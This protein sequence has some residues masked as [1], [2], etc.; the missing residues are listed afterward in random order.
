MNRIYVHVP[1]CAS[2][3]GYCAFYSIPSPGTG[4]IDAY[5][6]KMEKDFKDASGSCGKIDSLFIGGG[7]PTYLPAGKLQHLFKLIYASFEITAASEISIECNPETLTAEKAGI[8]A[9]FANRVSLGIQSFNPKFRKILGRQ[10]APSTIGKAMGLLSDNGISNIGCDLIYAIPEQTLDDWKDDLEKAVSLLLKHIS[11][12]SLTIE[13]GSLLAERMLNFE[14]RIP[15]NELKSIIDAKHMPPESSQLEPATDH[16]Q[17][18]TDF[19]VEMW[20]LAGTFLR[21]N[22]FKR[23]EISN[24]SKTGSECRHNLEIWYG[25]TYMG[26]G[27]AAS[28]FDGRNR[29]TNPAHLKEWLAGAKPEL[30]LIPEERRARE[31]FAMGLRTSQGWDKK[32]FLRRTGFGIDICRKE[33]D[34]L[35]SLRLLHEG[36]ENINCTE[37]GLLL[38]NEVAERLI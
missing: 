38:W 28:S 13:E 10:G 22:G 4:E 34:Q 27:P 11:A 5:L 30:D 37:K 36:S 1:F 19:S 3:C 9:K 20:K 24:Y 32:Y 33:I 29:W 35:L 2:K 12:Y 23:Y 6:D 14:C 31:I 18:T 16:G 15:N 21:K 7:T 17:L 26:F 25:D 8:I